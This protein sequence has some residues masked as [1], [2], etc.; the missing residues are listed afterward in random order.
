[1]HGVHI[2]LRAFFIHFFCEANSRVTG[3]FKLTGGAITK[4]KLAK[5]DIVHG[6]HSKKPMQP[7]NN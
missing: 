5:H 4:E 1:M 7:T 2:T 6:T 3:Q